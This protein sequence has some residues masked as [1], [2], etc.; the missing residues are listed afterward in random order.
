MK[1]T[2]QTFFS[3]FGVLFINVFSSVILSR[4]LTP[5]DRGV[6]LGVTMWGGFILG[7]CDIG[8]YAATVY[9]WGKSKDQEKKDV[10]MTML[11][12]ALAT[13][14]VCLLIVAAL[15]DWM[16]K[17]HLVEIETVAANVFFA[18]SLAG[19]VTT[20]INGVLAAEQRF[21]IINL[22]RIGLPVVLTSFWLIYFLTGAL[23]ISMCLFT[24]AIVPI[25]SLLLVVW[26]VRSYFLSPGR[27]RLRLF[28]HAVW[29]SLRGYGGSL[30]NVI[31]SNSSQLLLFSLTPSALAYFQTAGST[32]GVLWSIPR[33]VGVT[34]FPV[35]VKTTHDQLHFNVCRIF[36]ITV[37]ATL[38]GMIALGSAVPLLIPL[39]FG[40]PYSAAVL[41]ALILLPNALFGGLSDV[42]GNALSSTGRTFH[43]TIANAGNVGATLFTL[44]LTLPYWG[45]DGV[46][47]SSLIGF[48]VSFVIRIVWYSRSIRPISLRELIPTII[49]VRELIGIGLGAI[50]GFNQ[51][52]RRKPSVLTAKKG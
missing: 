45:L 3:M 31:G 22:A 28:K 44:T 49:E 27:F 25:F 4:G 46:A 43:A 30:I 26:Q 47:I 37:I 39:L 10:F 7:L 13:G 29:Y 50:R 5:E 14:I 20:M 33:A 8:I 1:H 41:P 24:T 52:I 42:L 15:A 35:L 40:S 16:I 2:V 19:P 18:S 12:W 51:K 36:R 11:I 32:A 6:Y 38:F 9:L 34:S 23:S 17:G 21:S 48:V